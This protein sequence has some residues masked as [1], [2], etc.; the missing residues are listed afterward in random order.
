MNLKHLTDKSILETTEALIRQENELLV[1]ILHHLREIDRRRLYSTLG[2]GSLFAYV[3]GHLGQSEDQAYRRINAMR[4]LNEVPEIEE[5]IEAGALSLS[6]LSL[7]QSHFRKEAQCGSKPITK[8]EKIELLE[9]IENKSAREAQKIVLARSSQPAA[10]IPDRV[11]PISSDLDEI[12]FAAPSG[13]KEKIEKLK[14]LLAHK[15]P[16]LSLGELVDQLCDLGLKEWDPAQKQVRE[17]KSPATSRKQ[18]AT[19]GPAARA[20]TPISQAAIRREVWRRAQS[21]CQKC[22]SVFALEIDHIVP[23]AKGGGSEVENRRL[24]CRS[25]NQRAAIEHFGLRKMDRYRTLR[26]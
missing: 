4:L 11:K 1:S 21:R 8:A 24:L 25:C 22:R 3:V 18:R 7:A 17:R 16:N 23:R 15:N 6:N 9:K 14:G 19:D 2:H 12:K 20:E 26:G 10:V 13:L 5:K